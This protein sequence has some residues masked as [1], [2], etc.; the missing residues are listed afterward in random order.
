MTTAVDVVVIGGGIAGASLTRALASEG[1]GV[2]VLEASVEF[3]DRVRGESMQAW[4]VG[5]AR[6]LGVEDALMKAA[7]TS[8]PPGASTSPAATIRGTS[9]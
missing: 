8:L 5:E 1:L 6:R 9:R 3:P 7:R 4:G 2:T